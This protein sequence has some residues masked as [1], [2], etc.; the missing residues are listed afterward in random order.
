MTPPSSL[1][2]RILADAAKRP[3]RTRGQG[4]LRATVAYSI[5]T[6]G[7][8]A[9]FQ[10]W[11]GMSHSAGRPGSLT[12][13]IAAGAVLLA[14]AA[15]SVAWWR[16]RSLVGRPASFLLATAALLPVATFVWM[17]SFSGHYAEPFQRVGW[18][19]LGMTL[20]GGSL[21]LGAVATL[22]NRTVAVHA[23]V[24]GAALGVTAGSWAAVLVDLWCPLT[25][26]PHVLVGHVL[27]LVI[28]A[29]VGGV[30][31]HRVLRIRPR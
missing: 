6:A 14:A 3:V 1:R 23:P 5:A 28:L 19:C 26:V 20:F 22:R 16:G 12:F 9:L 25:N 18:R 10:A 21:L 31:G 11:G 7:A 30:L 17:V 8:L 15:T 27:P 29:A 2:D 13:G 4:R 24:S